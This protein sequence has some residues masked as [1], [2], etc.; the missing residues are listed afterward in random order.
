VILVIAPIGE[1]HTLRGHAPKRGQS[2]RET[3]VLHDAGLAIENEQIIA[4]GEANEI[5]N[6]FPKANTLEASHS[7]VTPGLVDCHTHLVWAGDRSDEFIRRCHG[8]SYL[9]IA[10]S[11]GGIL[12]TANAVSES[13][14]E[15]LTNGIIKRSKTCLSYGTT[16]LEIK[17]SYGLS[18]EGC[19]KELDAIAD[20]RQSIAQNI[21]CTFMGAHA[22]PC[23]K[24][25][26]DYLRLLE[27]KLIPMAAT[28][29]AQPA[30]NDV[31]CDTGAFT[32]EEAEWILR[33]GIKHGLIPK[34]H[35]DEFETLG[36]VEMACAL[37]AAS[38]DHL[39]KSGPKQIAALAASNT[40]AV[41]MPGTAFYLQKAFADARKII[42]SECIL[43]LGTDFNPG[44]SVIASMPFVM[45]LAVA[46]M[47]ML[48]TEALSAATINSAFA[49]GL[50]DGT[51][52]LQQGSPAD[53]CI[54]P[55]KKLEELIYEFTHIKPK[56]TFIR[57]QI[58]W[59]DP[60]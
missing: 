22:F 31:F 53:I 10:A 11:G 48:S 49:V 59:E 44:S 24:Q 32:L 36:G 27:E 25:R 35:A 28:H 39:L 38:C 20:A 8:E 16:T 3:G 34:I 56:T 57:G 47:G 1:L 26:L 46:H 15:S 33:A 5:L 55:V 21:V 13:S 29:K 17:A 30:F 52:T 23:K 7:L 50:N 40:V 9:D 14:I 58:A 41:T 43:A 42:D 45:G 18:E 60:L 12:A 19:K 37:G 2:M 54:W 4:V 6:R 51:G